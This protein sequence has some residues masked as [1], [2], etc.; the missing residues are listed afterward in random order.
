[1]SDA[2]SPGRRETISGNIQIGPGP[3]EI[4]VEGLED[5][6]RTARPDEL[7]GEANPT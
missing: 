1:M 3:D 5:E 6:E 7:S 2:G 4:L